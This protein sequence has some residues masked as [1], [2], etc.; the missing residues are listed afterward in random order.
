MKHLRLALIGFGTVGQG[1]A[2]ILLADRESLASQQNVQIDIVAV[3][4]LLKGAVYD[5][6]GLDIAALLD[7]G[8]GG[9]LAT[10]PDK[11]GLVRSLV[12][13]ATISQSNAD[14]VVEV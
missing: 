1:L 4:D 12:A 9:N 7:A 8:R 11:P 6:K 14:V 3:S 2:E 5:P 13:L 10:Y